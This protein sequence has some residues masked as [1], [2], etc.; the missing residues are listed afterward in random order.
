MR[1]TVFRILAGILGLLGIFAGILESRAQADSGYWPSW[2]P[3]L[4][5]L[6]WSAFFLWFAATGRPWS[7]SFDR[8][9][10]D[11]HEDG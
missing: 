7:A 6:V 3:S 11:K 5:V 2:L 1:K 9:V 10:L 4:A 8:S